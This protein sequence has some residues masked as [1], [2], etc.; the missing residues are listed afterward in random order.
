[1]TAPVER[2]VETMLPT[3][4]GVFRCIGYRSVSGVEH[5]ALVVGEPSASDT[6]VPVR[7]HSECL[8]GDALGSRRCD[9]GAQLDAAMGAVV[10][11]GV[12]VVVYVR[13]H[14]GRGIGLVEKL[15]AYSLQDTGLDTVDANVELGHPVDAREY[16]D[17]VAILADLGVERVRLLTNNPRKRDALDSLD[18]VEI[19]PLLISPSESNAGYLAT[20]RDRLGHLIPRRS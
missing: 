14:E 18:H 16:G 15:R 12:G 9:C 3:E 19:A 10:E 8:T 7:I 20:K 2:V 4:H 1:M 6:A 17:A 13:G 11:A 5:V